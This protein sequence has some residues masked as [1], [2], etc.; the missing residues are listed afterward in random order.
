MPHIAFRNRPNF[1]GGSYSN[2]MGMH[3]GR[4]RKFPDI[5]EKGLRRL[6]RMVLF[7]SEHGH[8]SVKKNAALMGLPTDDVI[9]VKCDDRGKMCPKS[10]EEQ[11]LMLKGEVSILVC[12]QH[13]KK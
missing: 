1:V 8:Y 7:T 5:K 9:K 6:P 13:I 4:F 2:L 11:I 10:L 3:L 12:N